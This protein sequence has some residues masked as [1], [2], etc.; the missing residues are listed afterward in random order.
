MR[1][2]KCHSMGGPPGLETTKEFQVMR[3]CR[4]IPGVARCPP[5]PSFIHTNAIEPSATVADKV[6]VYAESQVICGV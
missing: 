6:L 3:S 5:L 2:G 4:R 1:P